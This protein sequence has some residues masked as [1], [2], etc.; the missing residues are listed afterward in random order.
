MGCVTGKPLSQ[1]GIAGR[2]EATGL[3]LYYAARDFLRN[4]EFAKRHG[5]APGIASSSGISQ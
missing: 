4:P 2:N 3:G 5:I 1:G